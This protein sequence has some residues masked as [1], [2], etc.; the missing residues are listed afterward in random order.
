MK[1]YKGR[2][3]GWRSG[4]RKWREG[5]RRIY[6]LDGGSSRKDPSLNYPVGKTPSFF[7]VKAVANIIHVT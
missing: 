2:K 4:G 7:S 6:I 3:L 5:K 1:T